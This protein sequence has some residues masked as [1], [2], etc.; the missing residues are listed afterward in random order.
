[1]SGD[2]LDMR[3]IMVARTGIDDPVSLRSMSN[4]NSRKTSV[5]FVNFLSL[6]LLPG[7]LTADAAAAQDPPLGYAFRCSVQMIN[8]SP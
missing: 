5:K 6:A 2:E 4:P 8:T 7:T 3:A 1:V